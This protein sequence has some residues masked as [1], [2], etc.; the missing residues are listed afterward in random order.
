MSKDSTQTSS[1]Q[2]DKATYD[3]QQLSRQI[4]AAM[5]G[6]LGFKGLE[7]AA[8]GITSP[9]MPDYQQQIA[10][11]AEMQRG[12]AGLMANQAATQA[13]VFG[14]TGGRGEVLR[15][16][17][18]RGV[19]E[20]E[21]MA[22]T[23]ADQARWQQALALMGPFL[24]LGSIGGQTTTQQM[25]G[26]TFG[27]ILGGLTSLAGAV[28]GIGTAISGIGGLFRRGESGRSF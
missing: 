28:P 12:Q 7:G 14:G 20:G 22:M 9:G 24:G 19:N 15:S 11:Q 3:W 25:P 26:N 2:P 8:G 6:G 1:V 13:G 4:A 17:L 21:Q 18:L 16:G 23:Q 10:R 27:G 5:A